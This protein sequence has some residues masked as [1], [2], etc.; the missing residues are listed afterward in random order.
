MAWRPY[1]YLIAGELD[2]TTPGKVVGWM[3]FAGLKDKITFNLEGNFHRDIRGAKI[4]FF[5]DA[6]HN[7]VNEVEAKEYVENIN[8][9]QAGKVGD[10]TAG[11]P[12]QDYSD[13]PY[14][15]WYGVDNGR[16]VIE[17]ESNQVEVVG[18]PIPAI[19]SDPISRDEQTDNLTNFMKDIMDIL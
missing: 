19:E 5:G 7:E 10:M 14:L 11:L 12:P 2:N 15:E 9:H 18:K 3:K 17:L 13:Y 6:M 4:K 16:I 1:E 8:T